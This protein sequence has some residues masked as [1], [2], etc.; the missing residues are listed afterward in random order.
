MRNLFRTGYCTAAIAAGILFLGATNLQ[1]QVSLARTTNV[2]QGGTVAGKTTNI[3]PNLFRQNALSRPIL[4]PK[5]TRR[6][7]NNP[8]LNNNLFPNSNQPGFYGPGVNPYGT[9]PNT[10]Q[11][12]YPGMYPGY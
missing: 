6:I 7:N 1:A 11:G 10:Y 12:G 2:Q 9:Y 8:A 3:N 4:Q 5:Q